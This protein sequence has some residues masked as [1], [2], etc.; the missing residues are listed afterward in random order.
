M[1]LLDEDLILLN[2]PRC[3]S[4]TTELSIIKSSIKYRYAST[5][6]F[7]VVSHY[8]TTL[9]DFYRNTEHLPHGHFRLYEC[10]KLFG[11]R[12]SISITR[13]YFDKFLSS[14]TFF[15]ELMNY[16]TTTLN[17]E[18]IT[19]DFIKAKFNSDFVNVIEN[20]PE[21]LH[22]TLLSILNIDDSNLSIKL[23]KSLLIFN[24]IKW[25]QCNEKVK[26]EFDINELDK[27]KA[28]IE[29]RYNTEVVI[30]H[31][32]KSNKDTAFPNLIVSDQLRSYIWKTFEKKY[33][34][35]SIF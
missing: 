23:S 14:L 31:E 5:Q 8:S 24:S 13:D 7:K 9:E 22:N 26:Y 29:N 21:E 27:F 18:A 17:T 35:K 1:F 15:Y 33:H 28:F 4:Y 3:A 6:N 20:K 11:N 30:S 34:T 16:S 10:Y 12:N 19:E 2:V 32:N 25:W